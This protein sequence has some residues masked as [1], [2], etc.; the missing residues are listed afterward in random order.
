MACAGPLRTV[1]FC[2]LGW[3][4]ATTATAA[5]PNSLERGRYLVETVAFCGVCHNTRDA[6]GR[7]RPGME[8]AGGRVMSMNEVRTVLSNIPPGSIRAVV[9]NITPDAETGIG[10][11]TDSEIATAI[12]E[13]RRPDGSIIGPPMPIALYRGISDRDLTAI[14]R[15]LRTVP[16]VRH[17]VTERSTYPFALGP[18][19][20]TVGHVPDPPDDPVARG[21]YIAG[22]LAHC[23]ECHTPLLSVVQRDWTRIG[24]GGMPIEGPWGIVVAPN[25]TSNRDYGIGGWTDDQI[26]GA[27]T[28][29]IAAD[30][31]RLL[32][33]MGAR[34]AIYSQITNGDLHDL[35]TYLRS[36]TSQ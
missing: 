28:R 15:Y 31:R 27:I 24:A 18:Y 26:L 13:G 34:A 11:W 1:F 35:I 7:M 23:M 25:I 36:L 6:D 22:P 3:L 30:G 8:L 19:G 9:P 29:G 17:A 2:W 14:V 16:P 4:A 12:R 10:R 5:Q 21:A 32:P 33:P 20:P